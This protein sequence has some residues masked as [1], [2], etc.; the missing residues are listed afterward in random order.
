MESLPS[1]IATDRK[2]PLRA[3]IM[4]ATALSVA[5][6]HV[7]LPHVLPQGP[8]AWPLLVARTV[9]FVVGAGV[10][11]ALSR[12]L[13]WVLCAAL[14]ILLP[15]ALRP[16]SGILPGVRALLFAGGPFICLAAAGLAG[17]VVLRRRRVGGSR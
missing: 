12:G 9:L 17:V 13:P 1:G 7:L 15:F 3:R 4:I 2:R 10:I 14:L 5:A 6:A 8:T 11:L 16:L